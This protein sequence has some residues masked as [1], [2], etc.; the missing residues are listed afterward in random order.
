MPPNNLAGFDRKVTIQVFLKNTEFAQSQHRLPTDQTAAKEAIVHESI[1]AY[2]K[3]N[4]ANSWGST[5]TPAP[6][7]TRRPDWR[8]APLDEPGY[9]AD[10]NEVVIQHRRLF[11][12]REKSLDIG[13]DSQ[14]FIKKILPDPPE[15]PVP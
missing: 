7:T 8:R 6:S 10:K 12:Y 13:P 3:L 15:V 11:R 5:T 9:P 4:P 2:I 1:H 14:R